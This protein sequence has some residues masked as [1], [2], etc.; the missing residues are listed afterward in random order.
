MAR[1]MGAADFR[2]RIGWQ[3]LDFLILA[4]N[5]VNLPGKPSRRRL[6]T[7]ACPMVFS[8]SLAPITATASGLKNASRE[9][10]RM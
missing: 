7:R 6:R 5:R 9:D 10:L 3:P 2:D 1:S 4:V 8:F